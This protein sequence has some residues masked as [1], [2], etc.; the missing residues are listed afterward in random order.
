ML[1]TFRGIGTRTHVT[2]SLQQK[3]TYFPSSNDEAKLHV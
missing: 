2:V 1:T 3:Y